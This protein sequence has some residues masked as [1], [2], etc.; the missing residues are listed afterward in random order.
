MALGKSHLAMPMKYR[1][2][3]ASRGLPSKIRVVIVPRLEPRKAI[4]QQR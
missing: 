3:A 4:S 1:A 2:N